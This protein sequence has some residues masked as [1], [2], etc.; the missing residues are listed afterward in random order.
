MQFWLIFSSHS[1]EINSENN[2]PLGFS[3]LLVW[4]QN[5]NPYNNISK[6]VE[7]ISVNPSSFINF[8]FI[9]LLNTSSFEK[10]KNSFLAISD[11]FNWPNKLFTNEEYFE[12]SSEFEV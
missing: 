4:R 11:I 5:L 1:L 2:S 7:S 12:Y 3:Q 8:G 9:I 10:S 6:D